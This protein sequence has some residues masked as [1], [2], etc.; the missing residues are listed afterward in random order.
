MG[1]IARNG[2]THAWH[3]VPTAWFA[4]QPATAEYVPEAFASEGFIHLTF[5]TADVIDV[6]NRYY[7]AV[8]GD[9]LALWIDLTR[10]RAPVE[11]FTTDVR[12][13][14]PHLHGPLERDAIVSIHTVQREVD[15][16][17]IAIDTPPAHAD[18]ANER[19]TR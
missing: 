19:S 6:G 2:N 8:P 15:G 5:T 7:R 16:T 17:F 18:A 10:C 1:S 11:Y 13:Q 3:L 4:A 14:F 9:W 12:H